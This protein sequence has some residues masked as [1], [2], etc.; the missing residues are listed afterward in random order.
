MIDLFTYA[1]ERGLDLNSI[2]MIDKS[3][4]NP[5]CAWCLIENNQ[6]LG[7]G[8]HGMCARHKQQQQE[9]RRAAKRARHTPLLILTL[10]LTFIFLSLSAESASCDTGNHQ[11][12][13]Q[14][15][16]D[17]HALARADANANGI[18]PDLFERQ[19]YAE[20]KFNPS[21]LS[22]AGAE[23]IAQIMPSTA[24]DW[25]VDPWNVTAS[26][27]TAAQHMDWYL[28]KYGSYDKALACYNAGC[29]N[30]LWAE[31]HC[32]DYYWCLPGATR[33]YIV[34]IMGYVP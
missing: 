29:G 24:Q 7:N 14:T 19:I 6:P 17:Y 27:Y 15:G 2:S 18:D 4:S 12:N 10:I 28:K 13:S 11:V 34:T 5:D 23:G 1:R 30:L 22:P 3:I 33:A 32:T 20:S 25:N 16:T 26:L 8:S 21:A 9:K 31:Q